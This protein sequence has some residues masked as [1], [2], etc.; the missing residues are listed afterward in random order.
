MATSFELSG[1]VRGDNGK[2]ASRRLRCHGQVPAILYGGGEQPLALSLNHNEIL[3]NLEHEAFY[4]HVLT[5]KVGKDAH[6]AILKDIQ[7]HPAKREVLHLD[8]QR[9][10]AGEQIRV[11][12]PLHFINEDTAPGVKAGGALSRHMIDLEILCIP[13]K[14]PEYIEVD[15]GALE[16]GDSIHLSEIKVPEG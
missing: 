13:S 8:L 12:V 6:Q 3:R 11:H 4:S 7:R 9:V 14:L 5:I 15:L 1:E 10:K 2:G 16:I